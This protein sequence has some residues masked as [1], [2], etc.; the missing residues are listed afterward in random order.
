MRVPG[1]ALSGAAARR[2]LD[3]SD[4][5]PS[6]LPQLLAAAS[7]PGSVDE[8]RGEEAARAA[9]RSSVQTAPAAVG[10]PRA[11]RARTATAILTAKILAA[12]VLTTGTA[13][14]VA[15]ATNSHSA[16]LQESPAGS[17]A[18]NAGVGGV[19]PSGVATSATALP[20]DGTSPS[21]GPTERDDDE[22]VGDGTVPSPQSQAPPSA[23][24]G[25]CE[26]RCTTETTPAP[27]TSS[28]QLGPPAS[29]PQAGNGNTTAKKNA[30][31]PK[32]EKTANNGKK[33]DE[34]NS[35]D[36]ENSDNGNKSDDAKKNDKK[37]EA[38]GNG[39]AK[40]AGGEKGSGKK[41][42]DKATT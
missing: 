5:G 14:G 11:A 20:A 35:N 18:D 28:G 37:D 13:G 27:A 15:V 6:P 32:K 33:S 25:R 22:T 2:L 34:G 12:L 1:A 9:F 31:K 26:A 10:T 4:D 16:H 42:D 24:T 41:T 36:E 29:T 23:L 30:D 7:G 40:H 21:P 39:Q 3:G 8:L 17:S 19:S 38:G